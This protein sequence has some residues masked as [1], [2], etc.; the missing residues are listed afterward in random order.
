[1]S[2]HSLVSPH[3]A[4]PYSSHIK[5]WNNSAFLGVAVL[6]KIPLFQ[7][8]TLLNSSFKFKLSKISIYAQYSLAKSIVVLFH[9]FTS[10]SSLLS[11]HLTSF[12]LFLSLFIL[13][14][15]KV[16]LSKNNLTISFLSSLG[17]DNKVSNDN[18]FF[19]FPEF[20]RL[21]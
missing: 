20:S 11:I 1:M 4:F 14:P 12:F 5:S 16:I 21:L 17:R 15:T 6:F 9:I 10:I 3:R 2:F 13:P 19:D 7:N 8:D 18:S